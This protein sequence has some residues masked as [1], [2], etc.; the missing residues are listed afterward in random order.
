[1]VLVV[2]IF[3]AGFSWT[4]FFGLYINAFLLFLVVLYSMSL[5]VFK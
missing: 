3:A 1:M 4:Y 2:F 5:T